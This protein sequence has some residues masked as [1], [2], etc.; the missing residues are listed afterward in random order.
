MMPTE[1]VSTRA[2]LASHREDTGCRN[3]TINVEINPDSY[4]HRDTQPETRNV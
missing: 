3:T 1:H 2:G 4:L